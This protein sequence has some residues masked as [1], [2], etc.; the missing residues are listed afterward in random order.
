[1][2]S[3]LPGFTAGYLAFNFGM[4][5]LI[6]ILVIVLLLFGAGRIRSLMREMGGGIA[7]FKKGMKEGSEEKKEDPPKQPPAPPSMN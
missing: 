5:E 6:I 4:P 7:E 1:M 3:V 2:I